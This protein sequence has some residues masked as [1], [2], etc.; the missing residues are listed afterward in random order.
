MEIE[1]QDG[2]YQGMGREQN[3]ELLSMGTEFQ[4]YEIKSPG[5]GWW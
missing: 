5:D 3:G 2:G 1:K 4:V